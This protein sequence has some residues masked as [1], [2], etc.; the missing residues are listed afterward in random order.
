MTF[1]EHLE[2]I[3][4][5]YRVSGY[6]VVVR[7]GPDELPAFAKD[8]QVEIVARREDGNVLASVKRDQSAMQLDTNLPKY[9]EMVENQ[10]GWRYDL[11]ILAP[12]RA[13]SAEI[14][15]V[16]EQSG[17]ALRRLLEDAERILASGMAAQAFVAA[18]AALE[19]AM[20]QRLR[21]EGSESG[22]GTSPRSMLDE[23]LSSGI[24]SYH[25]FGELKQLYQ[26]RNLLVH[27]F[28][29]PAT[30][31]TAVCFLIDTTRRLLEESRV[32]AQTA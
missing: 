15:D 25:S 30:K 6:Q 16:Q 8:F 18:W 26:I 2:D 7:P 14:P 3:A 21:V 1:E 22:W 27:G 31:P 20:R 10:P 17:E 9:A 4:G 29:A 12:E 24:I 19:S 28:A 11:F 23:L 5:N 13:P 32:A